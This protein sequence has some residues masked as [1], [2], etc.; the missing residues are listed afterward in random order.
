MATTG[1]CFSPP[2]RDTIEMLNFRQQG[3]T[4]E[5]EKVRIG[6]DMKQAP[7]DDESW[8]GSLGVVSSQLDERRQSPLGSDIEGRNGKLH[9]R[10]LAY[11]IPTKESLRV[12]VSTLA[13]LNESAPQTI[14]HVP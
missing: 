4:H 6:L 9:A 8:P 3:S 7:S 11:N 13:C 1:T 12:C 5:R 14:A 10:L 2:P